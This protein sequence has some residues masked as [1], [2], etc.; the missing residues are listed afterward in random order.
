M[1]NARTAPVAPAP[2]TSQQQEPVIAFRDATTERAQELPA[3]SGTITTGVQ[4]I[5]RTIEGSGFIFGIMLNIRATAAGNVAAVAFNEDAPWNALDSVILRDVNG[6][7]VNIDG[8]SLFLANLINKQYADDFF[9]ASTN[10]QLYNLVTGAGAT[11]GSFAGTLR[12]PVATNRRDLLGLVGNQDRSQSYELRTDINASGSVYTTAPTT[13]PP[14]TL[15]K[16]YESYSVPLGRSATGARQ[17]QLPAHYGSLHFLTR[18]RS[19]AAPAGGSSVQHYL[20]RIGNTIRWMALVFRANGSRATAETNAPSKIIFKVGDETLFNE[21]YWYRRALM[22]ERFG[23]DFPSGVLVYDTIHDFL[24][25]AGNE[26]GDDYYHTALVQSAQFEVTYPA[27]FGSTNNSLTL[28]T[29]D[30][31]L[32][33]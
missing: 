26:M 24:P 25:G 2:V 15:A 30:L 19:E 20:R 5:E 16:M 23:F 29:D 8:Y 11:G 27:G 4:R 3:E 17:D 32:R 14:F 12:V 22:F 10:T 28:I 9:D 6:E 18:T 7:L 31:I 33:Q 1:V 21:P 13:L